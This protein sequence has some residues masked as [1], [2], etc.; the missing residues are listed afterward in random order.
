M[1]V[2]T[3]PPPLQQ[4]KIHSSS[5]KDSL[6]THVPLDHNGLEYYGILALVHC[7]TQ[8]QYKQAGS[9]IPARLTARIIPLTMYGVCEFASVPVCFH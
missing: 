9:T 1:I 5:S 3:P 7:D 8:V 2:V 4:K 6:V